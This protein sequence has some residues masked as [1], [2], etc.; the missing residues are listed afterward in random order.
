MK[1]STAVNSLAS[2]LILGSIAVSPSCNAF[3]INRHG[4]VS[5]R[6]H[7]LSA[8]PTPE[9]SAKALSD[10]MA[11]AHEEKLRA[12][13]EAEAKRD[14]EVQALKK[15]LDELKATRGTSSIEFSGPAAAPSS[16]DDALEAYRKFMAEYIV[17]AAEQRYQ[18]V[19]EAEAKIT[20]KYEQ[21]LLLLGSGSATAAAAAP[22]VPKENT[23]FDKRNMNVSAAAS[24]G[25]SRWGDAEVKKANEAIASASSIPSAPAS[26]PV[27]APAEPK[28][29]LSNIPKEVIEADHGMRA[30]GGVGGLSLAERV[31]L[32]SSASAATTSTLATPI[33]NTVLFDKRNARVSEAAK[34]GV[35]RWGDLEI[36]KAVGALSNGAS[37]PAVAPKAEVS[38]ND[39]INLGAAI[40]S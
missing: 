36:K 17:K 3:V 33:S 37:A 30:D 19:K 35:S 26:A 7:Q 27:T 38:L 34:A 15:E 5:S 20:Q 40:L 29:D 28:I 12:V 8:L 39:R 23:T 4:A 13:K 16:S 31:L 18:A 24:A 14:A 11:K 2:Y 1:L 21:K 9:E 25:K 22:P 10:Y 32:G 6:S